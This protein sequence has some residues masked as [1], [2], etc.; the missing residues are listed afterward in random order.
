MTTI[1]QHSTNLSYYV[2]R[3]PS[4]QMTAR[5]RELQARNWAKVQDNGIIIIHRN[6]LDE[7]NRMLPSDKPA[8]KRVFV[9]AEMLEDGIGAHLG[10]NTVTN[11]GTDEARWS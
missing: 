4:E 10:W 5:A 9:T 7:F 3:E 2:V 6:F 1:K 11:P 8:T